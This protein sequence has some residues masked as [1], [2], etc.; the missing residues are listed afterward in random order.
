MKVKM[1]P[2]KDTNNINNKS[3]FL[4]SVK[5]SRHTMRDTEVITNGNPRYSEMNKKYF[6]IIR[7]TIH[8]LE[9]YIIM[10]LFIY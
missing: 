3:Y 7:R 1:Y 6:I 2:R 8:M 4:V 9:T 5:A 10:I